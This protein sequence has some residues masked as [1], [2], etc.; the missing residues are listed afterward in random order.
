MQDLRYIPTAHPHQSLGPHICDSM[1]HWQLPGV[2]QICCASFAVCSLT[3]TDDDQL[4]ARRAC[5]CLQIG[6]LGST[7]TC[8]YVQTA[9]QTGADGGVALGGY[10]HSQRPAGTCLLCICGHTAYDI[11]EASRHPKSQPWP[12]SGSGRSVPRC[13]LVEL[14]VQPAHGSHGRHVHAW[15]IHFWFHPARFS[16][17]CQQHTHMQAIRT[18]KHCDQDKTS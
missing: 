9:M 7:Y 17:K 4:N 5:S 3:K 10:A 1:D 15:H 16:L 8:L 11:R 13:Q 18:C 2:A 14:L 12:V 6:E